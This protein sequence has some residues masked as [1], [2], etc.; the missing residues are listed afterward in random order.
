MQQVALLGGLLVMACGQC[1]ICLF[2]A[3]AQCRELLGQVEF[4]GRLSGVF[5]TPQTCRELNDCGMYV[6]AVQA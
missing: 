1:S 4:C 3:E 6:I 2:I 5:Q